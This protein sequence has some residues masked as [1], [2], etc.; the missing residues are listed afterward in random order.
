MHRHLIASLTVIVGLVGALLTSA[1]SSA[2][3]PAPAAKKPSH[4]VVRVT[5]PDAQRPAEV[6]VAVN[7][8]DPDQVIAVSHQSGGQGKAPASFA[9]VSDNGGASWKATRQQDMPQRHQGDDAITF[10][11]EG[12]AHRA[13][14]AF[15]GI[16]MS[17][18][19][20]ASTGI[21]VS[22]FRDGAW[23]PPAPVVDHVNSVEPFEDK[24]WIVVDTLADSPHRGNMYVSWTRFDVYGSKNPAHKSHIYFSRSK[25]GG[26]TFSPAHRISDSPGDCQ[27]SSQTLMGAVPV[28]G[29]DGAVY[30]VWSG[31]EGIVFDKSTDGGWTFGPDKVLT[32][33]PG[34]WD[35]PVEG[36]IR[37]NGCPVL[38]VDLSSGPNRGS[39]YVNWIDKR[40]GDADVFLMAS[41]D[42]G[43]T[44]SEPI[45]VNDD[46][47]GNG[48]DQ[49]FTWMAVDPADG[50]INIVFY[51]RREK[52][53]TMTGVT[54]ARSVDGG[55]TFVNHKVDQEPFPCNRN[56][57]FGDY[58]GIA[59]AQGRVVAVYSHFLNRTQ[60]ALS[61]AVF[62]FKPGTQEAVEETDNKEPNGKPAKAPR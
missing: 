11:M 52:K 56:V 58:I 46:D 31:P 43:E 57:F 61:A 4:K 47:K 62:H 16:R 36:L 41:R 51:D 10:G 21:Y 59:A 9:Y 39:L 12:T 17:R 33:T 25:D 20:H 55:R 6:S 45:R 60:L 38:G 53:D 40:N 15:N 34:G 29:P 24:P 23:G 1:V 27:D 35:I 14:L 32:K 2:D 19:L 22:S 26:R 28:V 7:P 49:L 13:F 54:M 5:Q 30:V 50:S 8:A 37:H 3:D 42:K 44:W 48:K 18:P